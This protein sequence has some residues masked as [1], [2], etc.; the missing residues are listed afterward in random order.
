ME[1][2]K[3]RFL[4]FP[5]RYKK[6]YEFYK[7]HLSVF[8]TA[9]EID[10]ATDRRGL[11]K[12]TPNARKFILYVLAFFS[13]ADGV[14]MANL[15]ENFSSEVQVMEVR[16]FY[17]VQL[18]MEAI[19]SETYALLLQ[20]YVADKLERDKLIRAVDHF[21]C[22]KRKQ[23]WCVEY[24]DGKIPF[25]KRLVA[26]AVLEGVFFSAAFCSIYYLKK[27]GA[28]LPGLFF[29]NELISRDEGLHT[30]FACWLYN[31]LPSDQRLSQKEI[32]R[33]F[34]QAIEIE[35]N[36]CKEALPVNLIGMNADAMTRYVKFV[37]D[38]LLMDLGYD[39]MFDAKQPFNFMNLISLQGKTNFF[40]KRVPEYGRST[41]HE[42]GFKFS[43]DEDF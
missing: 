41:L 10:I 2:D 20:T 40:E 3:S 13:G 36:C 25:A 1:G 7:T 24:M 26:F 18:M 16:M 30:Q 39:K 11:A 29:S 38:R 42:D 17:A 31:Q 33:M 43:T 4:L 5:L 27:T 28:E 6:A 12:L 19:H 22:I 35:A 23:D 8:W 9:D 14:V 32:E 21:E 37:A 34:E 15:V